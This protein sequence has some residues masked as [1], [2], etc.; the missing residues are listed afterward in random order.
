MLNKTETRQLLKVIEEK[1]NNL[2]K[3]AEYIEGRLDSL[4]E[5]S[6]DDLKQVAIKHR[7]KA[8]KLMDIHQK[9]KKAF[10]EEK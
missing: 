3:A 1:V 7:H 9:L 4:Y 2:R 5:E 8:N 10:L 6:K